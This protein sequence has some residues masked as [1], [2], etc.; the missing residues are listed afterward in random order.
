MGVADG[1]GG[2]AEVWNR[3]C[4]CCWL[5][6]LLSLLFRGTHTTLQGKLH[7]KQAECRCSEIGCRQGQ[8]NAS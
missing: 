2:W 1:V 4:H 3:C 7:P 8:L 5:L 6:L